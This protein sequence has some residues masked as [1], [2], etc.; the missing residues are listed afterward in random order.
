[1]TNF[2]DFSIFIIYVLRER[3]ILFVME[4]Q[5]ISSKSNQLVVR[6]AKLK[7]K[8]YRKAEGLFKF[9][10][11]KLFFEAAN[12]GAP[13]EYVLVCESASAK[14]REEIEGKTSCQKLYVLSDDVFAKLT[15]E[16]SPEGVITICSNLEN[17]ENVY[18]MTS[19]STNAK[20]KRVLMLES[21]RDVGN[22]GTIIRSAKA[23]GIDLLRL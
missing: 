11:I 10:G 12:C 14:Y 17:I 18:D 13:I 1:M 21:V 2:N 19:L 16:Q 9:D 22:M 4:W 5:Y 3:S 15:D 7:D 20:N 6:L 8:K 23:F